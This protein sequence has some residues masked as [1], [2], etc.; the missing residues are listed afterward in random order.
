MVLVKYQKRYPMY[1]VILLV[2]RGTNAYKMACIQ[3]VVQVGL[4]LVV[5]V[6]ICYHK[7]WNLS[8]LVCTVRFVSFHISLTFY[9]S[10][11]RHAEVSSL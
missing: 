1:F 5:T 7:T 8:L 3:S 10:H 9:V 6:L 2:L 4:K 11:G